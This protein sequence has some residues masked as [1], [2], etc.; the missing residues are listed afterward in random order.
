MA[1]QRVPAFPA[2]NY[3]EWQVTI[4]DF[5]IPGRVCKAHVTKGTAGARWDVKEG[6]GRNGATATFQGKKLARFTIH[7]EAGWRNQES[8]EGDGH[9]LLWQVVQEVWKATST[10]KPLSVSH[11]VLDLVGVSSM[12]VESMD[13]PTYEGQTM[14]VTFDCIQFA[15]PA[16]APKNVTATPAGAS[17]LA[18][19]IGDTFLEKDAAS[20]KPAPPTAVGPKP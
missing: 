9:A 19:S 3:E 7:L 11:P 1:R 20:T 15:P 12:L 16:K 2:H 5:L 17:V 13:L 4:G 6:V 18:G 14:Q 10:G 8:D